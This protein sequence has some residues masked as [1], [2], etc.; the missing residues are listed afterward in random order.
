MRATIAAC[1]ASL[2]PLAVS[3][4]PPGSANPQV[5]AMVQEVSAQRIEARIRKIAA[6]GTRNSNLNLCDIAFEIPGCVAK[7]FGRL[8]IFFNL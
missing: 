8:T 7:F 2:L 1:L 3:A 4:A 6:F 5:A